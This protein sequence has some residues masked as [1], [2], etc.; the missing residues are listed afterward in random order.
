MGSLKLIKPFLQKYKFYLIFYIIC[1]LLTYPLES[2]LIPETFSKL[3]ESIKDNNFDISKN[4]FLNFYKKIGLLMLITTIAHKIIS[5]L[6]I[7]LMPEC[8]ELVQNIF[9]E[10]ILKYFENNYTD[11]ELGKILIRINGLP[12]ILRELTSDLFTWIIPKILT[13][14][15]INYYFFINDKILGIISILMLF[16]IFYINYKSFNKCINISHDKYEKYEEKSELLQDKLS[17]LYSIYSSGNINEEIQN[18]NDITKEYK[19]VHKEAIKCSNNLKNINNS[20]STLILFILSIYITYIFKTNK[21]TRQKLIALFMILLF[22][23]P[24]LSTIITYLPDYT[25]HLGTIKSVDEFID[26]IHKTQKIKPNINISEGNIII[27]NLT[28]S[29]NNK[30]LIFNNFNLNINAK[31]KIA[32]IGTSGNGKSSL[33]KLIMGYYE[34]PDNTIFIDNQDINKYNLNSIRKQIT[35]INQNTKLF[36]KTIFENIKYGN[37]STN[38]DI[39]TLFDTFKLNKIFVNLPDGFNTKVGVNGDSISGGQKQI[40]LLLRNYFNKNNIL[41]LDEPTSALD[42][43]TCNIVINIIKKISENATLIIITHDDN[44]FELINRKIKLDNG[45]IILDVTS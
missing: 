12:N 6:D 43:E 25:T 1:I 15:A 37:N 36:N 44:N 3:F 26:N 42:V 39:I 8:N 7:F 17:N 33:I 41:I 21:I 24:C 14:V 11:L 9:F 16:L 45:K 13:L 20:L 29:Y 35:Y 19:H 32:I 28:F 34:V 31:E 30:N 5:H 27:K 2:V 23:I 4:I 40:I 18:F 10:K 38:D 22:Y